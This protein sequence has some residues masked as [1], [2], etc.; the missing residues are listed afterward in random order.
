MHLF[1]GCGSPDLRLGNLHRLTKGESSTGCGEDLNESTNV[2]LC[3]CTNILPFREF[4]QAC[5]EPKRL[6]AARK[7]LESPLPSKSAQS[8][9]E[10]N[11]FVLTVFRPL[12]TSL[13]I[14]VHLLFKQR[15]SDTSSTH[16]RTRSVGRS[17][18]V[19]FFLFF[20]VRPAQQPR[21]FV[22]CT[23]RVHSTSRVREAGRGKNT[24]KTSWSN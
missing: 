19:V 23:D 20:G 21:F 2:L 7:E 12:P 11:Q 10:Y 13:H 4:V 3:C 6:I 24:G 15:S 18:N 16:P 22:S 5:L 8:H 9:Q 1:G 17:C 14:N